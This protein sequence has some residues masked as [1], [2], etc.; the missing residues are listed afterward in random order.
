MLTDLIRETYLH[1]QQEEALHHVEAVAEIAV[2]LANAYGMDAEK[3]K[4]AALLHDISAIRTPQEMYSTAKKRGLRIDPAEEKY[5]ALL[6]Q[7]ISK[8]IAQEDF[9]ITDVQILNAIECHTTLKTNACV[10]DKIIFIADKISRN[11]QDVPQYEDLLQIG[12]EQKLN[13]ACYL[14]I[15]HQFDNGLLVFAHQW[16]TDAYEELRKK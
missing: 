2:A 13:E 15:K 7:R 14:F 11:P 10:F 12:S 8:I 5:H 3:V 1:N 9:G 16:L 6:H 4:T